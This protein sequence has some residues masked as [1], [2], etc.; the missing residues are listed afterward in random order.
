MLTRWTR[1]AMAFQAEGSACAKAWRHSG[2]LQRA[3]ARAEAREAGRALP[4]RGLECQAKRFGFHPRSA[5]KTQKRDK[6]SL[7][8]S[9][10]LL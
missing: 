1:A 3:A 6:K 8:T 5:G 7:A 2:Y 4:S 9:E 10:K